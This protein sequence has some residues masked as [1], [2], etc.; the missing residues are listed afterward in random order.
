M[1]TCKRGDVR[2]SGE[3]APLDRSKEP[4]LGRLGLGAARDGRAELR[5]RA[6]R[7]AVHTQSQG[8]AP[9][10]EGSP[11][12][13][14]GARGEKRTTLE[15]TWPAVWGKGG[16]VRDPLSSGCTPRL[17]ALVHACVCVLTRNSAQG[18]P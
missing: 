6:P 11:P 7:P 3:T 17:P 4:G 5:P 13:L 9:G 18:E 15:G 2:A 12:A 1:R 16:W 10:E 14:P 8:E